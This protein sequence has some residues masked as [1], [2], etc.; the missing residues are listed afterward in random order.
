MYVEWEREDMEKIFEEK[1][2][3]GN[4]EMLWEFERLLEVAGEEYRGVRYD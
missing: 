3:W 2:E 1:S 4:G